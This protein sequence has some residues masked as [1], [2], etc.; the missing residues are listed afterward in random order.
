MQLKLKSI[1]SGKIQE[2]HDPCFSSAMFLNKAKAR[3]NS[4]KMEKVFLNLPATKEK[5][6]NQPLE[7]FCDYYIH[8]NW[9]H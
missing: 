3:R 6:R 9:E 7:N 4:L 5:L 2:I 1:E 8:E